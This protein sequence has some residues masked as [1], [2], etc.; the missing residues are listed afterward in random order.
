MRIS[1]TIRAFFMKVSILDAQR[2]IFEGVVSEVILPGIDG[3]LAVMD[4]HEPMFAALSHGYI[5]LQPI[6]KRVVVSHEA[7]EGHEVIKPI[8]IHQG[9]A[10]M[11]NNKLVILVE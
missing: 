6:A 1:V 3:E 11:K 5:R 10:R 9:L 7:K 2:T 8:I 4:D